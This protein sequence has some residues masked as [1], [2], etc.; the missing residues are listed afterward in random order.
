MI[1]VDM[2]SIRLRNRLNILK[3]KPEVY[4]KVDSIKIYCHLLKS[5][6]FFLMNMSL[7]FF[8]AES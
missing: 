2:E 3:I 5:F 4:D 7:I 1:T 8:S 6:N